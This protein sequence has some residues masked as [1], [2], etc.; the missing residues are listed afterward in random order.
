[1]STGEPSTGEP[2]RRGLNSPR[3][4]AGESSESEP[5]GIEPRFGPEGFRKTGPS[6]AGFLKRVFVAVLLAI[7]AIAVLVVA[8]VIGSVVALILLGGLAIVVVGLILKIVFRR[9][10]DRYPKTG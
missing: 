6:R 10:H 2:P 4:A 7:L 9:P 5:M 1:M 8:L 3:L